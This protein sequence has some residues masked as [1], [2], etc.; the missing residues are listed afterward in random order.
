[1]SIPP[2]RDDMEIDPVQYPDRLQAVA[3]AVNGLKDGLMRL[4]PLP[5]G[6]PGYEQRT[7]YNAG[8]LVGYIIKALFVALGIIG[9]TEVASAGL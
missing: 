7:V 3:P 4:K 6:E 8:Y 1:M 5:D 9:G 2:D